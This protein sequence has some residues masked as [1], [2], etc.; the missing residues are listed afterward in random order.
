MRHFRS[1]SSI[2]IENSFFSSESGSSGKKNTDNFYPIYLIQLEF[3]SY[4]TTTLQPVQYEKKTN[5]NFKENF[6]AFWSFHIRGM[7][8]P[9]CFENDTPF[10]SKTIPAL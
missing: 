5:V 6:Q 1:I 8:A 10:Q 9:T 4:P 7:R 2:L 3:Y